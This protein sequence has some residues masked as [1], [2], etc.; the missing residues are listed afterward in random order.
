MC[1]VTSG[2]Y[3]MLIELLDLILGIAFGFFHHGKEDYTGIIKN[4]AIAGIVM[5]IILALI[6]MYL[7]GGA[8]INVGFPGVLGI[9]LE[10]IIFV[11]IFILGAFI[12]DQVEK[13]R[14]R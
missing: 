4:G 8:S 13:L 5:G 9:V 10:I 2:E 3:G 6:S 1:N 11:I 14:N 12:G 7:P